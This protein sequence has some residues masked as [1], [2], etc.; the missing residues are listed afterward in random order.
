MME[1]HETS[2]GERSASVG[3]R[4]DFV[5]SLGR[6]LDALRSAL[7][8]LEAEPRS[9]T[10]RAQLQ[11]RIHAM[12]AAAGVLG[13]D[14]LAETLKTAEAALQRA[15]AE[16]V[17]RPA[18]LAELSRA[19]D[20]LPSLAWGA[21][22][23]VPPPAPARVEPS[24]LD[25]E[26]WPTVAMVFGGAALAAALES[27]ETPVEVVRSED[28]S[29]MRELAR[30]TGPDVILVDAD[31]RGARELVELLSHDPLVDP[32]PFV[33]IGTFD[34]P[35]A[36][37][38]FAGLGVAR[39]LPKPVT[40]GT[41]RR[42][43]LEVCQRGPSTPAPREPLGDVTVS[44]LAD[45][46]ASEIHRGLADSVETEAAMSTVPL[47]EGTDV[48]AAVWSA[49]ARV[50][51]LV[52]MRS[53][54]KVRFEP[55][56]PEGAI[57]LAPWTGAERS[58]GERALGG[59]R[60]DEGIPIS[61]RRVVVVDD[62]PAVVWFLSGLLEAAGAE[63][64]EAHDGERALE[65]ARSAW[66]DLVISDVLM[67]GLDGFALCREIKR[68]AA[69]R[70]VPVILLSWKE[71]L[72]QRVRELG[73]DADGYLRKEATASQVI[74][75]VRE[76]L[77]P[78]A[79]VEARIT[80]GGVVRG[81]LDGL[82]PRLIL[83]LACRRG[84]DLRVSFRDAVYLYEV[85]IRDGALCAAVRT[86]TDGSF[87]R[88]ERVLD[89]LIGVSA[90]RFAIA[91][92]QAPCRF[93][94]DGALD[95]VLAG[96][97][98]RAREAERALS[99]ASL[100]RIARLEV[101]LAQ[102]GGYAAVLPGDAA[103]VLRR[104]ADGASPRALL[105]SGISSR[106]LDGVL[107][108]LVRH[109]AVG[110]VVREDGQELDVT[111]APPAVV[112]AEL[113]A[114]AKHTRTPPPA[115]V[116]AAP[117]VAPAVFSFDLSP[118]PPAA[119]SELVDSK[120]WD[121]VRVSEYERS[122]LPLSTGVTPSAALDPER[123]A[124]ERFSREHTQPGIG[125]VAPVNTKVT[126]EA[127]PSA[128]SREAES[129]EDAPAPGA[130]AAV[131]AAALAP[132]EQP[133]MWTESSE[134]PPTELS[135]PPRGLLAGASEPAE[136]HE[137]SPA[138][139]SARDASPPQLAVRPVTM[140]PRPASP[141][142]GRAEPTSP[143][144]GRAEPTSPDAGRAE[145]PTPE[146]DAIGSS[147]HE[148]TPSRSSEP[149]P[150]AHAEPSEPG[151]DFHGESDEADSGGRGGA[152]PRAAAPEVAL[153]ATRKIEF[154]RRAPTVGS[155]ARPAPSRARE[156]RAPEGDVSAE[157]TPADD[158]APR[159]GANAGSKPLGALKLILAA[160]AAGAVAYLG[161]SHFVAEPGAAAPP[162]AKVTVSGPAS[163]AAT[164]PSPARV[165]DPSTSPT[166]AALTE[167][168]L[169]PGFELGEGKGLLEVNTP[170]DEVIYVDGTFVGRGPLRRVPLAPGSH[171][172]KTGDAGSAREDTVTVSA[173][174][175][176]QLTLAAPAK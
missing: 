140:P 121:E 112:D 36:A 57:P 159:S 141:D 134:A 1:A 151:P 149:S 86:A 45:R 6:R 115:L 80:M 83:Q 24:A 18:E 2:T 32:V 81:R 166:P 148:P 47:G 152:E 25:A 17:T 154:P 38:G 4:A 42:T 79:R 108:D 107:T 74:Q 10:R 68:D 46:I 171:T 118:E 87:E 11:R 163:A 157:R 164:T 117:A 155:G 97:I 142:A 43:V 53:G 114:A 35:E 156:E 73:A 126:D 84:G 12:G 175:R 82:S 160:S 133:N 70:D 26:G 59:S 105:E 143:E 122:P 125:D 48:L 138:P 144:A 55:D 77:R 61:G 110:R 13:F 123:A 111:A 137:P 20:L 39:V 34:H 21:K 88:G 91:P 15:A 162:A 116:A 8:T 29:E 158:E 100:L 174:R 113:I 176:A 41:L 78:R 14:A 104:L 31:R 27:D 101:D 147:S 71:D 7:R 167:L 124:A 67:P 33:L 75:R 173:G 172:V 19:L 98:G 65:L 161:V 40:P 76:V 103:A 58:A 5:A 106:L 50:R 37:A 94:F 63:V 119:T 30:V 102:L 28:S 51:E 52:T 128:P 89:A 169:P 120:G 168:P 85:E 66:P 150:A 69:I 96:S 136:E 56:G 153:P 109:G 3:A 44:A 135:E 130:E 127:F 54:G 90:G 170:G 9:P 145:P 72:L 62:D 49:V 132:E 95:Q 16:G 64:L 99:A 139:A 23:S 22:V 146:P 92:D 60:D 165:K 131:E 93:E 129:I